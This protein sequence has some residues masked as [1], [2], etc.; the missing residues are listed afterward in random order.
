MLCNALKWTSR[1]RVTP[2]GI[3]AVT[4]VSIGIGTSE[5]IVAYIR[6]Q[7]ETLRIVRTG[8][9]D[10]VFLRAP[11][12]RHE[13][14]HRGWVVPRIEVIIAGF[15]I[16]FFAGQFVI[17]RAVVGDGAFAAEG[18]EVG[19]VA[20]G[21]RRVGDDAGG[22]EMVRQI[23]WELLDRY[24][25]FSAE[26]LRMSLT[27]IGAVGVLV[28]AL[29]GKESLLRISGVPL[30]SKWSMAVSLLALGLSAG[31]ALAHRF[32]SS[33]S[34]AYRISLLRMRLRGR[35]AAEIAKEKAMRDGRLKLSGLSLLSAGSF[36]SIRALALAVSFIALLMTRIGS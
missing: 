31:A 5:W 19:V 25:A 3:V 16:A 18:V 6:I 15:G 2:A 14:A 12:G 24:Q 7:I 23:D 10:W 34:M 27:G 35:A 33:D 28:T 9:W 13:P 21:A 32:V 30:T 22:A 26:L 29:A 4:A 20:E 11:V 17:L 8:A 1:Q 36:L